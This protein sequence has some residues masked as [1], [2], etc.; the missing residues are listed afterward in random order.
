MNSDIV[1]ATGWY[2]DGMSTNANTSKRCY[3]AD[4]LNE[5]WEF[6]DEQMFSSSAKSYSLYVSKCKIF[7]GAGARTGFANFSIAN[8]P[9][10]KYHTRH[11]WWSSLLSGA[12]Y[13][14]N[15][16]LHL[17]YIEQDCFVW[18][19]DKA[20][21]YALIEDFPLYYGFGEYSFAPGWAENSFMFVKREFL[22][23]LISLIINS[24]A[25]RAVRPIL[26]IIF[27]ELFGDYFKAWPFG[28]GRKE[29]TNWKQDIFYKQQLTDIEIDKFMELKR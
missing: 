6:H 15:N 24:Q 16:D 25:D 5:W 18:G 12:M 20:I 27:H 29:V 10:A 9:N 14:Y 2:S 23:T 1:I 11:D 17:V 8:L 4:W 28:Y 21:E 26:E 7:P 22:P 3:D 19:L 13:A